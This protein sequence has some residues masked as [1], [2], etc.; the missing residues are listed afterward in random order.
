MAAAGSEELSSIFSLLDCYNL[1]FI[2]LE[3]FLCLDHV[4]LHRCRQVSTTENRPICTVLSSAGVSGLE[5]LHHV[6][7]VGDGARGGPGEAQ[8]GAPLEGGG[9]GSAGL[10][11][12]A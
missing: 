9:A 7:G 1:H 11:D 4:S 12:A 5:Q 3:I 6:P 10:A 2:K 8:A